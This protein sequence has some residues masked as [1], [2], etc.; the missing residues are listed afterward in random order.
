MNS[1]N[2]FGVKG[3]KSKFDLVFNVNK[4]AHEVFDIISQPELFSAI[5]P[6]IY[7]ITEKQKGLWRISEKLEFV[8]IP[9][10]FHYPAKV[11]CDQPNNEIKMAAVVFSVVSINL[12]FC[13]Q[14][15]QNQSTVTE[16]VAITSLFPVHPFVKQVFTKQHKIMFGNL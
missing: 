13:I 8:G 7:K 3:F 6:V 10:S 2:D 15:N 4:P 16:Q 14:Q 1:N 11:Q 12:K 9:F 5:H